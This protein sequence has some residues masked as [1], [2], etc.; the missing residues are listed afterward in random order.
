MQLADCGILFSQRGNASI[1]RECD[2]EVVIIQV[3][4]SIGAFIVQRCFHL[5][6]RVDEGFRFVDQIVLFTARN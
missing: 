4:L 6:Y 2:L 5:L 3:E 1:Q